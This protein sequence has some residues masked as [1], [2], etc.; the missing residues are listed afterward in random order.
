M[1]AWACQADIRPAG[2]AGRPVAGAGR[3]GYNPAAWTTWPRAPPR[4]YR[5]Q[6]PPGRSGG[7]APAAAGPAEGRPVAVESAPAPPPRPKRPTIADVARAAGVSRT[8]VSVVLNGGAEA[9]RI[10]EATRLAVVD[11]A[12]G[13]G[14][15][16]HFAAQSLRR[17][18]TGVITLLVG[19]LVNPLF[20]DMALVAQALGDARGYEVSIVN[21]GPQAAEVR[22]LSHLRGQRSDGVLVATGRHY[23]RQEA[24]RELL[25][26]VRQGLPAVLLI[27]R[28]PDPAVPVVRLDIEAGAYEAVV[29]LARLGHRRIAHLTIPGWDLDRDEVSSTAERYRAYRRA[30]ADA[31][32]LFD[33]AWLLVAAAGPIAAAASDPLAALHAQAFSPAA[34]RSM[35]RA[36]LALRPRPTAAFVYNDTMALGLIRG[37]QEAGARVPD[38]VAVVGFDGIEPGAFSSPALTT[39]AIPVAE[40]MGRACATLFD[41][42][43]GTAPAATEVVLPTRLV[44]RESCGGGAPVA[45]A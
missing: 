38:D 29:H 16:P 17:H 12:A 26:L 41:L 39:V 20:V 42:I 25:D 45:T 4:T 24:I 44:V 28:S 13:L 31:G 5:R 1:A 33:P 43:A 34:G 21:A 2:R 19:E 32:L 23:Q 22:A 40:L 3:D 10:S 8:T 15:T 37:L 18:Q 14:Y 9:L 27:D 35:A 6:G 36:L 7:D 11:T 30:L